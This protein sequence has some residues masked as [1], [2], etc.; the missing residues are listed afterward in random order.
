MLRSLKLQHPEITSAY[1]RQDNAGCYHSS[2]TILSALVLSS[3]SK[4]QV[5]Q[6]DFSDPQGDKGACDRKVAQVKAH[7]RSFANE[8][9]SVTSPSLK[10]PKSL[11]LPSSHEEVFLGCAS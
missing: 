1:F 4:I 7:V 5:K 9:N 8:G 11:K 3:R 2:C 10:L 6:I